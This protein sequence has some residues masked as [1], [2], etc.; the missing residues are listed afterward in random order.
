MIEHSKQPDE[1]QL[2][3]WNRLIEKMKEENG[4]SNS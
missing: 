3:E 4:E 1:K 2:E